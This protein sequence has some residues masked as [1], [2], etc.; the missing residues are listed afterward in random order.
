M[1]YK[2]VNKLS[3]TNWKCRSFQLT[4]IHPYTQ[5]WKMR[6]MKNAESLWIIDTIIILQPNLYLLCKHIFYK[7]QYK[8]RIT[9]FIFAWRWGSLRKTN[10][11]LYFTV[12]EILWCVAY[13]AFVWIIQEVLKSC[14]F[15]SSDFIRLHKTSSTLILCL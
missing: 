9:A 8:K 5:Y 11:F 13:F 4:R 1:R 6:Y 15:I 12:V 3:N 7:N 10:F 14:H 2:R